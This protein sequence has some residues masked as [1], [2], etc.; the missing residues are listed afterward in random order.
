MRSVAV[1]FKTHAGPLRNP[2]PTPFASQQSP[3]P[4]HPEREFPNAVSSFRNFQTLLQAPQTATPECLTAVSQALEL[5]VILPGDLLDRPDYASIYRTLAQKRPHILEGILTLFFEAN[6]LHEKK[7]AYDPAPELSK[8]LFR[9][10]AIVEWAGDVRRRE[11]LLAHMGLAISEDAHLAMASHV[12]ILNQHVRENLGTPKNAQWFYE[13]T[14]SVRTGQGNIEHPTAAP[15]AFSRVDEN[16]GGL[17]RDFCRKSSDRFWAV[18]GAIASLGFGIPAIFLGFSEIGTPLLTISSASALSLLV[19][20]VSFFNAKSPTSNVNV[21]IRQHAFHRAL[22][23]I[24][25]KRFNAVRS[26]IAYFSCLQRQ[27][28]AL[29]AW[30]FFLENAFSKPTT[31]SACVSLEAPSGFFIHY[32]NTEFFL[33]RDRFYGL[34]DQMRTFIAQGE[35]LLQKAGDILEPIFANRDNF[36]GHVLCDQLEQVAIPETLERDLHA[37]NADNFFHF[38]R[39]HATGMRTPEGQSGFLGQFPTATFTIE[40][41]LFPRWADLIIARQ[42][43]LESFKMLQREFALYEKIFGKYAHAKVSDFTQKISALQ[44]R[45]T[46]LQGDEPAGLWWKTLVDQSPS[47]WSDATTHAALEK[48]F[49]ELHGDLEPVRAVLAYRNSLVGRGRFHMPTNGEIESALNQF[50]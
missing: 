7:S 6:P 47:T 18:A 31:N 21:L 38:L 35:Q 23:K 13:K 39:R 49:A 12:K 17:Y 32:A 33:L 29:S 22:A 16:M 26:R 14:R 19:S 44:A 9:L 4:F 28:S 1:H 20:M 43:L 3:L 15:L 42:N 48:T 24:P 8:D 2:R 41:D 5:A 46:A 27:V 40:R 45:L 10:A 50:S 25:L 30:A 36:D 11:Q 37:I 34:R